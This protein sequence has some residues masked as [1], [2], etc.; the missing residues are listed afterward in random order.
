VK[1]VFFALEVEVDGPIGD[2][3]LSRDVGD[4]GVEVAVMSEDCCGRAQ[5][6]FAL[7]A[8]YCSDGVY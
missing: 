8:G 1:D 4:F 7:I 6:R 3:C 2:A 5:D